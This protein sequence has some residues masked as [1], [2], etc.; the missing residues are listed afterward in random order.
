MY[1]DQRLKT[2]L[3]EAAVLTEHVIYGFSFLIA[4][5]AMY[6]DRMVGGRY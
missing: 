1:L 6:V 4:S 2:Y 5:I 3:L